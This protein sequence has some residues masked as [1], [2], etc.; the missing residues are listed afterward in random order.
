MNF[1]IKIKV[2]AK[3]KFDKIDFDRKLIGNSILLCFVLLFFH[4]LAFY[5]V[6][7]LS[8]IRISSEIVDKREKNTQKKSNFQFDLEKDKIF[9]INL[10]DFEIFNS[11]FLN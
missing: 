10:L 1:K 5:T 8:K 2:W 6:C 9:C 11:Y 7:C 4:F 3:K